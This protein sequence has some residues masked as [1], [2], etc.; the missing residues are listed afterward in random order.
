[1][2]TTM[3]TDTP[4]QLSKSPSVTGSVMERSLTNLSMPLPDILFWVLVVAAIYNIL[5]AVYEYGQL[6]GHRTVYVIRGSNAR[7]E[8]PSPDSTDSEES[9]ESIGGDSTDSYD[10]EDQYI[11]EGK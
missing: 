8:Y 10:G 2:G 6:K 4:D 5:K 9:S 1:M 3:F 11:P 7:N